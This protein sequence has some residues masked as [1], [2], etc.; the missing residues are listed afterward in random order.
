MRGQKGVW[1][2]GGWKEEDMV[3]IRRMMITEHRI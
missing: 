1:D 3:L 2:G